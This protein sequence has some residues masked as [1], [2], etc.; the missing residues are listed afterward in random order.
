MCL[1]AKRFE[2]P[3]YNRLANK[4][5]AA[6][7]CERL[8]IQHYILTEKLSRWKVHAY[9][10]CHL[11]YW[12]LFCCFWR[13]ERSDGSSSCCEGGS[14]QYG[15]HPPQQRSRHLSCYQGLF[16]RYAFILLQA[17]ELPSWIWK[18]FGGFH[19]MYIVIPLIEMCG[20]DW[21]KSR[22]VV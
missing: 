12:K 10:L 15:S 13:T 17:V 2:R 19:V 16:L 7:R 8:K 9:N 18:L 4:S 5:V 14:C 20:C 1:V 22:H 21:F 11:F 6:L 3:S